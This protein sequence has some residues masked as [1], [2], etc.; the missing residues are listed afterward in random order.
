MEFSTIIKFGTIAIPSELKDKLEALNDSKVVVSIKKYRHN[1][2]KAQNRYY[3]GVVVK[4]IQAY[5]KD[6]LGEE[7]TKEEIHLYLV[8]NIL[9]RIPE[10][11]VVMGDHILTYKDVETSKMSTEEFGEYIMK[12]QKHFAEKDIDIPDPDPFY[13]INLKEIL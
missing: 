10:V 11:N 5:S 6:I 8:H 7:Y 12:I 1:R 13:G 2:S 3:W 4:T 9:E